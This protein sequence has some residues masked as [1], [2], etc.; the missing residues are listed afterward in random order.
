MRFRARHGSNTVR[1]RGR[2]GSHALPS[3]MTPTK[4]TARVLD[5]LQ[6]GDRVRDTVVRGLFAEAGKTGAVSLK[7]QADLRRG[8][9]NGVARAPETVRMTLGRHPELAIDAARGR[10]MA[11]LADIKSGVDP[12]ETGAAGVVAGGATW[13]LEEAYRQYGVERPGQER[14][15]ADMRARLDRY[16]PDWKSRPIASIT[17]AEFRERYYKIQ[18][19]VAAGV[20]LPKGRARSEKATG[21]RSANAVLGDLRAVWRL[22]AGVFRLAEIDSPTRGVGK[23]TKERPVHQVIAP[24]GLGAWWQRVRALPRREMHLLG[25]LSGLRPANLVSI[26]RA[27]IDLP[28]RVVTFPA[29]R[30]KGRRVFDLPLSAPM[31]EVIER[32]LARSEVLFPVEAG[33]RWLFPTYSRDRKSVIATQTWYEGSPGAE[34]ITGHGLRHT[35]SNVAESVGV[36]NNRRLLLLAQRVP[37]IAGRY[38]DDRALWGELLEA[39]ERISA[40]LV[41]LMH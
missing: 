38:L 26:E 22:A 20:Y 30:M 11:L 15:L 24:G 28:R 1:A 31:V 14:T 6:P 21:A 41:E 16:L 32:A 12:R 9:R 18:A 3:T 7:I 10:A 5:R 35:Y 25:L 2:H 33:N 13:T 23:R 17:A 27:W 4:L 40:R 34:I 36:P 19:D 29:E 39:Q 37:G 8:P